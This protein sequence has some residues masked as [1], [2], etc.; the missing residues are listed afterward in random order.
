M[1]AERNLSHGKCTGKYHNLIIISL[2]PPPH[3]KIEM[4]RNSYRILFLLSSHSHRVHDKSE[5]IFNAFRLEVQ[6]RE[7]EITM[8]KAFVSYFPLHPPPRSRLIFFFIPQLF[9]RGS[10]FIFLSYYV[11]QS[12][13]AACGK[14]RRK[15]CM[16][17]R[18]KCLQW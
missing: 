16:R 8:G 2:F 1:K 4:K 6:L 10:S 9:Q 18:K 17:E 13:R 14:G 11:E 5:E 7:N 3:K 15:N 12:S